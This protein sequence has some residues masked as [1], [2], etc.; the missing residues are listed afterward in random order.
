MTALT[1]EQ[2]LKLLAEER[3]EL[4]RVTDWGI[5]CIDKKSPL[6]GHGWSK[7]CIGQDSLDEIAGLLGYE[8]EVMRTSYC[9]A[10]FMLTVYGCWWAVVWKKSEIEQEIDAVERTI[11]V[12]ATDKLT[13][14][15]AAVQEII[16]RECE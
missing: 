7:E 1:F 14:S 8:Y 4:F 9:G 15:K 6:E 11:N 2:S 12:G 5:H 16:K 13:A 3:P 10:G